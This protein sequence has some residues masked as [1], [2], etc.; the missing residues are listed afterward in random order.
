MGLL[1]INNDNPVVE[2]RNYARVR[3]VSMRQALMRAGVCDISTFYRWIDRGDGPAGKL[4][5]IRAA[6]DSIAAEVPGFDA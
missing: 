6:I 3:D 1:M 2:I 4:R 5:S